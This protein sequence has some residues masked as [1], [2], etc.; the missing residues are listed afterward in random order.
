M[1][2]ITSGMNAE[3]ISGKIVP[4]LN[5]EAQ[6]IER[7]IVDVDRLVR[8]TSENWKG[9]DAK[10]FE[11]KWNSEF[12]NQLKKLGQELKQLADTARK[13]ADRQRDTS[14]SL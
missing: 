11:Q 13:N 4:G 10:Q 7:T 12:K 8:E 14:A 6:E 5:R 3:V 2:N 1:A 9:S